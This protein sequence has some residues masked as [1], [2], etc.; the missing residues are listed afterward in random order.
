MFKKL[1]NGR[2]AKNE[3]GLT[4]IELLAVIVILAIISA[5]AIPAI[6]NIIENTRYNAAKADAIN[7]LNAANLYFTDEPDQS[8]VTVST[9]KT[10]KYLDNAG[11]L[12]SVATTA[13]VTKGSP[14]SLTA[15]NVPY[16][17]TT[18]TIT[19][20]GATLQSINGDK[21]KPSKGTVTAITA[22]VAP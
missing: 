1:K 14:N 6:G 10:E 21:Q 19:F 22:T 12:E 2:I 16:S 13:T 5:I 17:G 15:T 18:K 9:L 20:T 7:V 4:L 8:S 3:K 11:K